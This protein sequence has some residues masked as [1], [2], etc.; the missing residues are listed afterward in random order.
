[1]T[2]DLTKIASQVAAAGK[3]EAASQEAEVDRVVNAAAALVS[4]WAGPD[5]PV[6][7]LTEATTR[8]SGWLLQ[9]PS[10]SITSDK[11]GNQSSDYAVGQLSALR[12][13]GAM[14]ILSPFKRRRAGS[15]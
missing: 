9:T 5:T 11:V 10:H 1:M 4:Q 3:D 14:A 7:I 15:L 12:F 2:L 6:E 8:V 13:S